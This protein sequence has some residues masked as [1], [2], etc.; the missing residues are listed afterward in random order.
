MGKYALHHNT[1]LK[2]QQQVPGA[3]DI[4]RLKVHSISYQVSLLQMGK[5]VVNNYDQGGGG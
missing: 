4:K 2:W 3:N 1:H 5:G